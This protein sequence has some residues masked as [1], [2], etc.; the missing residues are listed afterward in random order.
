[1]SDI[2]RDGYRMGLGD[3]LVDLR[4]L[5]APARSVVGV[6]IDTGTGATVVALPHDR[7]FNLDVRYR[8]SEAWAVTRVLSRRSYD[9]RGATFYGDVHPAAGHWRRTTG[10]PRAPTIE[11][12]YTA[13]S[14]TLT[15]RD[16]PPATGP[17][18][19]PWWPANL[20]PPASPGVRRWAW[21]D[22]SSSR[23]VKR[24][25]QRWRKEHARFEARQ[26]ELRAGACAPRKA[27][28]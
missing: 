12:D 26:R 9:K 3:L 5:E 23:S 13:V 16:Y 20:V 11:I 1:M 25:W 7:C 17:L 2:P 10:D 18:H 24:R 28:Q 4:R 8:T 21:R 6:R 22:E 15:V 14:G 27:T 19:E